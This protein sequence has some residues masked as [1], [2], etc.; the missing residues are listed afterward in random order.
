MHGDSSK[1]TAHVKIVETSMLPIQTQ[2]QKHI[3]PE[4]GHQIVDERQ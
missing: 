1:S 4:M 3:P 2:K